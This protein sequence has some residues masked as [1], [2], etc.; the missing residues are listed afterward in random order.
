MKLFVLHKCTLV[1][2]LGLG[3]RHHDSASSNHVVDILVAVGAV[4]HHRGDPTEGTTLT[5]S[6]P[7]VLRNLIK[8]THVVVAIRGKL[9]KMRGDTVRQKIRN[10]F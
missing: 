7:A 1:P 4:I 9:G 8:Q 10:I 2:V 6:N 5:S 3:Q